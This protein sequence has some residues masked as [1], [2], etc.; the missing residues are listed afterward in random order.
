MTDHYIPRKSG[1][2]EMLK[3]NNCN[4]KPN[5]AIPVYVSEHSRTCECGETAAGDT[6]TSQLILPHCRGTHQQSDQRQIADDRC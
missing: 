5:K 1:I 6:L 3:F 4:R 2:I